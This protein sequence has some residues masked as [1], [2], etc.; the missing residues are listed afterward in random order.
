MSYLPSVQGLRFW[1]AATVG[2]AVVAVAYFWPLPLRLTNG[3]G[4]DPGDPLLNTWI[5]WWTA[6]RTP[7]TADWWNAPAFAPM[8]HSLALSE[9][10]LGLW[11]ITAPLLAL[12]LSPVAVYNG[13]LIAS[14]ALCALAACLLVEHLT[15]SRAAGVVAGCL[16]GVAPYRLAQLAHLQVLASWWGPI[17]LLALHRQSAEGGWR[18]A[19]VF[20]VGWLLLGLTS[21]Y[22]L[23]FFTLV[24]ACAA[25]WLFARR[26][27]WQRAWPLLVTTAGAALVMVPLLLTYARV[28]EYQGLTRQPKEIDEYSADATHL[29]I[30]PTLS[31]FWGRGEH[32]GYAEI[33]CFPGVALIAGVLLTVAMH[34]AH[35]RAVDGR[36]PS[37]AATD[38]GAPRWPALAAALLASVPLGLAAIAA[39]SPGEHVIAGIRFSLSTPAKSLT[40]A[41]ALLVLAAAVSRSGRQLFRRRSALTLYALLAAATW[42]MTL[43][44]K[45]RVAGV[46][47][48]YH[49]P[50]AWLMALPGGLAMRVPPRFWLW[51]VLALAV[52]TGYGV[53]ALQRR[54]PR[55]GLVTAV[56]LSLAALADGWPRSMPVADLPASLPRESGALAS[57]RVL[58]LPLGEATR[59]LAAMW[60]GRSHGKPVVN[61]YS[62]YDPAHYRLLKQALK[63]ADPD[64]LQ[65]LAEPDGAS[66]VLDTA[67]DGAA[68]MLDALRRADATPRGQTGQWRYFELSPRAA[69][70]QPRG[71]RV[72]PGRVV[73]MDGV[74]V[75]R[76]TTDADRYSR[77]FTAAPQRAG[78]GVTA[79]FDNP[80]DV[81][82]LELGLG[83]FAEDY[84]IRLLVEAEIEGVWRVLYDGPT[85]AM[86]LRATLAVPTDPRIHAPLQPA[87]TR[88]LRIRA[89]QDHPIKYWSISSL[90]VFV[91]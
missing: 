45:A 68:A 31:R 47:V 82:V 18:W 27:V 5:L 79:Q 48:M 8:P 36:V 39:H 65:V 71:R 19:V 61:G 10:L 15:G 21:G 56:L 9:H 52:V 1:G 16:Y 3:I 37:N 26:G 74:D 43:G 90:A 77:W 64:A 88:T 49:A 32:E 46:T 91:P 25:A 76:E 7:L 22:H 41:W 55:A 29:A 70:V 62:G 73:D 28:H 85:S 84:P 69:P 78:Q 59:D 6:S 50:Y 87:R 13:L 12:G 54:S 24:A 83:V 89:A 2:Y 33:A 58:E 14:L 17:A 23:V 81:R 67:A 44:P 63:D 75:T 20:A 86:A 60:R 66:V 42:L 53:A 40:V 72:Q 80:I 30:A 38:A 11:P 57:A 34:I 51:T 4:H 35:L